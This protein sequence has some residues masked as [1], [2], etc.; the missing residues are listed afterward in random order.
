MDLPINMQAAGTIPDGGAGLAGAAPDEIATAIPRARPLAMPAQAALLFL[1]DTAALILA[2]LASYFLWPHLVL[3]QP[4]TLYLPMLPLLALFPLIYVAQ[5]LYP[6]LGLG[7]AEVIRRLASGTS[8]AFV[9][10]AG[11]SF[12]LKIPPEHSRVA[13][14]LAWLLSLALL[15]AVRFVAVTGARRFSWWGEPTVVIGNRVQIER[16]LDLLRDSRSLGYRVVGA[17]CSDTVNHGDVLGGVPVFG[18]PEALAAVGDAGI[19]TALVFGGR[20]FDG[21]GRAGAVNR[22]LGL[23]QLQKRFRHVVML[24]GNESLPVEHVQV[25]NLGTV[26]G[27]EFSNELLRRENRIV[28]R[29]LDVILGTFFLLVSAPVILACGLLVKLVS[30]GPIF[31]TQEREGLGGRKIRIWKL[32]TMY[33]DAERRLLEHLETDAELRSEWE[34]K[35]KLARDP[36]VVRGIG[37]FLRRFSIDELPQLW[38]VVTGTMSLVGPRPLPDYHLRLFRPEFMELRRSVRPG[39]TGLWQITVRN[40]GALDEHQRYDSYYI[41]NWS[42]WLDLY[43]LA[44]TVGSVLAARGAF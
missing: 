33:E 11:A 29:M 23:D 25:R 38:C 35:C 27:I 44:R 1:S 22:S 34:E 37:P 2:A 6:G 19:R 32:R 14:A 3:G 41:R 17:L 9:M 20:S 13:F 8:L 5:G 10:L 43:I 42:V 26:F 15:P 7:A 24:R 4:M 12:V 39:V 36:R 18:G 16:T 40:D 31:F 30:R 21:R 28:K